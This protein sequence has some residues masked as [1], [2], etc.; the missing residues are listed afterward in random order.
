MASCTNT[1]HVCTKLK[2]ILLLRLITILNNYAWSIGLLFQ[3]AFCQP[4]KFTTGGMVPMKGT[5]MAMGTWF[6][7]TVTTQ[8][9]NGIFVHVDVIAT[10]NSTICVVS[11]ICY[12]CCHHP[13]HPH[14]IP[15]NPLL[16][17]SNINAFLEKNYQKLMKIS[18]KLVNRLVLKKLIAIQF[19]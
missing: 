13:P 6:S 7:S 1:S 8:P 4:S 15:T 16:C 5:N 18:Q 11:L 19:C 9:C 10:L 17:W 14:V 12:S 3:S 2:F